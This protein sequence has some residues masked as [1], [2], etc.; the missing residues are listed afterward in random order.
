MSESS[1]YQADALEQVAVN[2]FYGWGYNFYRLENQLRTDDLLVRQKVGSLLGESRALVE[3]AQSAWRRLHLPPPTRAN[4]LPRPEAI[5][6]ARVLEDLSNRIG[7]VEAVIR[8]LPV[9]ET[10]RMTQLY[11]EE[12]PTLMALGACD[13]RL[14]GL[15]GVLREIL[16]GKDADW[17][18]ANLPAI[19]E[20]IKLIQAG[21]RERQEIL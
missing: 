10:D 2:L 18:L 20:G 21:V 14:V 13:R 3:A 1:F 11:R 19:R 12:A 16:D 17:M 4:P 15:A 9:P 5:A 6:S 8:T 7:Q